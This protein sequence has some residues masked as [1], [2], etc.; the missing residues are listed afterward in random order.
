MREAR[1][2][3]LT[4]HLDEQPLPGLIRTLH[5]QHKTGR[6]QVDYAESPAAFHFEQGSLVDARLGALRGLEALMLALSLPGAPFN[7]NPLVKPPER[8]VEERERQFIRELLDAA[9]AGT[10]L[11]VPASSALPAEAETTTPRVVPLRGAALPPA[12]GERLALPAPADESLVY[13]VNAALAAHSRRFSR[14]RAAYAAV[15]ALLLLLTFLSRLRNPVAPAAPP[16]PPQAVQQTAP[17]AASPPADERLRPADSS[18]GADPADVPATARRDEPARVE[19]PSRE[20]RQSSPAGAASSRGA[21]PLPVGQTQTSAEAGVGGA[22]GEPPA[23]RE[24]AANARGES[25]VRILLR[26]E[27]GRVLQAVVQNSRPGME[28]YEALA[29]RMARQRRYPADFNGQDTLQLKVRQ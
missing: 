1:F 22:G 19:R 21:A 27:R 12:A 4:G 10:A 9:P 23:G 2:M 11:D 26:V 28:S 14:E 6:L 16:S 5:A 20:T 25:S 18:G 7:F 15:I 8:T 3:V 29:L 24:R 13:E 17:D